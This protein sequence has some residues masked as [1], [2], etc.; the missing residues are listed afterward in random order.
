MPAL[1]VTHRTSSVSHCT[2]EG[3]RSLGR[4]RERERCGKKE[5]GGREERGKEEGEIGTV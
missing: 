1:S 3:G 5:G 2:M 4:K